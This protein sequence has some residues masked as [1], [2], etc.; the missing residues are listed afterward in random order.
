MQWNWSLQTLEILLLPISLPNKAMVSPCRLCL[1]Y[2]IPNFYREVSWRARIVSGLVSTPSSV[3]TWLKIPLIVYLYLS[4]AP[5]G[6]EVS[7]QK[8][9]HLVQAHCLESFCRY[10]WETGTF[11][12]QIIPLSDAMWIFAWYSKKYTFVL[13]KL[14]SEQKGNEP[15]VAYSI[16]FFR[17]K[18]HM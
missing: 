1:A 2:A 17:I 18:Y 4:K 16:H 12:R 13:R 7:D 9:R 10:G 5:W 3:Y 11:S 8:G 15:W 6:Y 14:S